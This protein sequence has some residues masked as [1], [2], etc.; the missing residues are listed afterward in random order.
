MWCLNLPGTMKPHLVLCGSGCSSVCLAVTEDTLERLC[1]YDLSH[2]TLVEFGIIS[3]YLFHSK[4]LP[5]FLSPFQS[6]DLC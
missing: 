3:Q 2:T 6:G 4:T 1:K 5:R